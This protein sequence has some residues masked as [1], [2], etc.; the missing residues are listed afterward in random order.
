MRTWLRVGLA[1]VL[2][3]GVLA[4]AGGASNAAPFARA[5]FRPSAVQAPWVLFGDE[6]D[7][8][9]PGTD[10]FGLDTDGA[11]ALRLVFQPLLVAWA[12]W[13]CDTWPLLR[14]RLRAR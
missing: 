10:A 3:G 12:V 13:A 5:K 8:A 7:S 1:V 11:R 6:G 14:D 2:T 9:D 4:V